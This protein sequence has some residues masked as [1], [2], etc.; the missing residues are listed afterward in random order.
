MTTGPAKARI[1]EART[2]EAGAT[3]AG[4][5]EARAAPKV[6]LMLSTWSFGRRANAAAWDGLAGGGAALDAVESAGRN[7]EEDASNHTV[8]LG[9]W[10]DAAGD[11]T[12]DAAVMLSPTRSGAVCCVRN[13]L[14]VM[15]LARAVMEQTPHK[16]LAGHG[17]ERLADEVGLTRIDLLTPAARAGWEA[18]KNDGAAPGVVA[19]I[20]ELGLARDEPKNQPAIVPPPGPGHDAD[21][22]DSSTR[23]SSIRDRPPGDRPPGDRP[24]GDR[25]AGHGTAGGDATRTGVRGSGARGS[26]ARGSGATRGAPGEPASH[27]TIGVLAIDAHGVIAGGC[28]TSGLAFKAP[29]RVG[30]SPLIGQGL[31]VDPHVGA[32]VATGHGELVMGVCGAFLAVEALR[33]GASPGEAAREVIWRIVETA[34][35]TQT[36]GKIETAAKIEMA[37]TPE[38]TAAGETDAATN[39]NAAADQRTADRAT[40]A[41][42]LTA[43]GELSADSQVGVIVTTSDGAFGCFALRPGFCVAV[44]SPG[45]DELVAAEAWFAS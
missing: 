37:E 8:G 43:A 34:Q 44:R 3:E 7:A 19:N 14:N 23:D 9:G 13:Y 16:L 21:A 30:D 35:T 25:S 41:T 20:E 27:D 11:V 42:N 31:Y 15:T 32:A 45:R 22:G 2:T 24:T 6:P 1:T 18:W 33:R 40:V 4:A 39:A 12:L 28:T 29:G 10:P 38:P 26:G 36:A 17:A 5:T